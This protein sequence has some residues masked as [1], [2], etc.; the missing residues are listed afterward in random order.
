MFEIKVKG[1]RLP[2][3][4]G[5]YETERKITQEVEVDV[6]IGMSGKAFIEQEDIDHTVDYTKVRPIVREVLEDGIVLIESMAYR[7]QKKVENLHPDITYVEVTVHKWPQ[8][9]GKHNGVA[10]TFKS[11]G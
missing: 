7:I 4:G 8:L 2:F 9:G 1:L 6:V 10:V 11:G 3:K 5:Y